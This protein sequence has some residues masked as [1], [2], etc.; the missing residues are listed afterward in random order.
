MHMLNGEAWVD[1]DANRIEAHGGCI[2]K[3]DD[4]YYW[5][6]EDKRKM[7]SP[8]RSELCGVSCYRSKDLKDWEYRG[9]VLKPETDD[10][11]HPL[12]WDKICERPKV[13]YN[14]R[15]DK[16]VMFMHLEDSSYEFARVGCAVCDSP[17]GDFRFSHSFKPNGFQSRDLSVFVDK[18]NAYL[19]TAS[20][21]N[22]CLRAVKLSKDYLDFTEENIYV[23]PITGKNQSREAPAVFKHNGRYYCITSGCTGWS[24]NAADIAVADNI[25][26]EWKSLGNPF[27]GLDADKSFYGQPA[28]VLEKDGKYILMMDRWNR[29]D[30]SSSGYIWLE[31][32]FDESD[33]PYIEFSAEP[34]LGN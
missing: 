13:V 8:G 4:N 3:W 19:F 32:K 7:I 14:K 20:H 2:L 33:Q 16:F 31:I 34:Y 10:P 22:S 24:P 18:G 27:R 28:Y 12:Y 21:W 23:Y 17:D 6:G 25:M 1:S 15:T 9:T 11:S 30:L 29:D 26:G 5:Y